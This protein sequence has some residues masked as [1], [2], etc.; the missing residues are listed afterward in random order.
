MDT[1]R[2]F[3][4]RQ[5]PMSFG[6][7]QRQSW[8]LTNDGDIVADNNDYDDDNDVQLGNNTF[9][10]RNVKIEEQTDEDQPTLRAERT[11]KTARQSMIE[12]KT[13]EA[14]I[15]AQTLTYESFVKTC[16]S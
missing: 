16:R 7:I 13:H 14:D 11:Q 12:R 2:W 9:Y 5:K 4:F 1:C 8:S 15:R 10:K 3:V 6:D